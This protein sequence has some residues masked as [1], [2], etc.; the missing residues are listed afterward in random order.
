MEKKFIIILICVWLILLLYVLLFCNKPI[1]II[2]KVIW[3]YWDN[4]NI[5]LS[6]QTCI[7]SWEIHN[8]DHTI[9]I[10]N[11]KNLNSSIY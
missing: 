6:V 8:P 9:V 5:P 3:T 4:D 11:K 10:L 7:T 1:Y 2:P